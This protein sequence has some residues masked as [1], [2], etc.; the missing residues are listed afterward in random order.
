MTEEAVKDWNSEVKGYNFKDNI[1]SKV[2]CGHYTQV[3]F[4]SFSFLFLIK[5]CVVGLG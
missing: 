3:C 2:P 4:L 1:C 5:M